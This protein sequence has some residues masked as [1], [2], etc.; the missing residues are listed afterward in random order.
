MSG[1]LLVENLRWS[2]GLSTCVPCPA[3]GAPSDNFRGTESR[4]KHTIKEERIAF[5][6]ALREVLERFLLRFVIQLSGQLRRLK[7]THH[8]C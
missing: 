5:S 6:C 2:M 3:T 8:V 7:A 4:I 1:S